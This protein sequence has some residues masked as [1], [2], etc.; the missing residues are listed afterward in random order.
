MVVEAGYRLSVTRQLVEALEREGRELAVRAA[1][2]DSAARSGGA[3]AA[4]GW[5]CAGRSAA[6]RSSCR[7]R[8]L[9]ASADRG[10]RGLLRR[11]LRG[12]RRAGGA[13]DG[14]A[15]RGAH[16]SAPTRQ[17]QQAVPM[18]AQRGSDRRPLRRAAGA[19]P[20][21]GGGLRAAAR[22]ECWARRA[23]DRRAPARPAAGRGP[24]ARVGRGAVRLAAAAGAA[25][26]VVAHRGH[27]VARH[28][29]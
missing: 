9:V 29:Q 4:S 14:H 17:H 23:Q 7:E 12:A 16:A 1:A 18:T 6:R 15:G 20:R 11:H 27:E 25:R 28:R 5:A 24:A 3:G 10:D 21:I 2:A 8:P 22:M 26:T 19:E 13:S